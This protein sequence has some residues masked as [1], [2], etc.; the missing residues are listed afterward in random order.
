MNKVDD[1]PHKGVWV[2]YILSFLTPFTVLISGVIAIVY[3]GYH[4]NKGEDDEVVTSHYYGLIRSFFLY[5]TFFVVLI[6]SVATA[7]GIL[8]GVS[9]YWLHS[10]LV[11]KIAY[12][13][14]VFGGF[15]AFLAII[16]W[17]WRMIQGMRQLK[18]NE[19][20]QPLP[21]PNWTHMRQS[22]TP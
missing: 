5:L 20:H 12:M 2:A 19:V 13:I 22:K 10:R 9:D 1:S 15:F 6:I 8:V 21:G 14:P 3:A 17:L 11:D 18:N 7:N 4:L 16:V